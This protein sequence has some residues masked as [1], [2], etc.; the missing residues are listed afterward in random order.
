[1]FSP[2]ITVALQVILQR[3]QQECIPFLVNDLEAF[4][5]GR[6][7]LNSLNSTVNLPSKE[8][9][10]TLLISK[11]AECQLEFNFVLPSVQSATRTLRLRHSVGKFS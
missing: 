8:F 7:N 11:V 4:A 5:F 1:M 6:S 3:L 2:T 10:K 9:F